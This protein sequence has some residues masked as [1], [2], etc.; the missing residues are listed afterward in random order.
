MSQVGMNWKIALLQ[1]SQVCVNWKTQTANKVIRIA[2]CIVLR[3]ALD[4]RNQQRIPFC[5][6]VYT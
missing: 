3:K 4:N 6:I 2:V 5:L 1:V